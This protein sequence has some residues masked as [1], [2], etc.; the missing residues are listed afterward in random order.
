MYSVIETEEFLCVFIKGFVGSLGLLFQ[1][2]DCINHGEKGG[3]LHLQTFFEFD[4]QSGITFGLQMCEDGS[5]SLQSGNAVLS[6]MLII[7]QICSLLRGILNF[8]DPLKEILTLL[9]VKMGN[10]IKPE[11]QTGLSILARNGRDSGLIG[12]SIFLQ[13][14]IKLRLL[15]LNGG[16]KI[17]IHMNQLLDSFF[18]HTVLVG[19]SSG[20]WNWRVR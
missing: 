1:R 14:A 3:E 9:S 12:R 20:H 7:G 4:P 10:S 16:T 11:P 17:L 19:R 8:A 5:A 15:L 6:P 2:V 18:Q 13:E